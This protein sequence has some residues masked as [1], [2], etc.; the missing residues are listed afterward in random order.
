MTFNEQLTRARNEALEEYEVALDTLRAA[1]SLS[2][3][4][5]TLALDLAKKAGVLAM[6][7]TA[8]YM[9]N[10]NMERDEIVADLDVLHKIRPRTE[11][12]VAFIATMNDATAAVIRKLKAMEV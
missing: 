9:M 6:T 10:A 12:D 3:P 11:T 2:G 8:W 5:A 7:R 4:V 1:A